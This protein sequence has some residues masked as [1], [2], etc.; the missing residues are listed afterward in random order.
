MSN[1]CAFYSIE[2]TFVQ[3]RDLSDENHEI[4]GAI[5]KIYV[6]CNSRSTILTHDIFHNKLP[7]KKAFRIDLEP[8]K[9][10]IK[11]S[12]NNWCV[13]LNDDAHQNRISWI[14]SGIKYGTPDKGDL[15]EDCHR[16][17]RQYYMQKEGR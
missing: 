14:K 17:L 12:A 3:K 1:R 6:F 7:E 9:Q 2:E 8:F 10:E 11:P 13:N 16:I 15:E 4:I 5:F